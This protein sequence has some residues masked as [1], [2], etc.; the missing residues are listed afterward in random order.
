MKIGRRRNRL[1]EFAGAYLAASA[2][3]WLAPATRVSNHH[4][5]HAASDRRRHKVQHRLHSLPPGVTDP[6]ENLPSGWEVW[7]EGGEYTYYNVV[8][9]PYYER[10]TT[11]HPFYGDVRSAE[12]IAADAALE[13]LVAGVEAPFLPL[14]GP[15]E[16]EGVTPSLGGRVAGALPESTSGDGAP[17][18]A[19]ESTG[20]SGAW[21]ASGDAPPTG[22]WDAP[23]SDTYTP[24]LGDRVDAALDALAAD[25]EPYTPQLGGRVDAT[26]DALASE[27]AWDDSGAAEAS[28]DTEWAEPEAPSRALDLFA[29]ALTDEQLADAGLDESRVIG[30]DGRPLDADDAADGMPT[31]A[32]DVEDFLDFIEEQEEEEIE[33]Y[34]ERLGVVPSHELIEVDEDGDPITETARMTYVDEAT[35]IGCTLCAGIAPSTFQMTDDHGRARVFNQ[36]GEDEETITEAISTCPVSCIHFVPWDELVRLEQERAEVMTAYNFKSRLVGND[37]FLYAEGGG[38]SQDISTNS[39]LR[40]NN[41]PSNECEDCPMFGVGDRVNGKA[42]GNCPTNGCLGCPLATEYPEFSKIR[43]RRDRKRRNLIRQRKEEAAER[44]GLGSAE[45]RE[46]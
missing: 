13:A 38:Q 16:G 25:P 8:E 20:T 11:V 39:M 18:D 5:W 15:D 3:G 2:H 6:Q 41:C 29:S 37:G 9:D 33:F 23:A 17:R 28:W 21:D 14:D 26:L 44:L 1:F 7:D 31:A 12:A 27:T 43:A 42:C 22:A 45:G 36:E 46:L 4:V 10:P 35:C 19:P 32:V 24:P 34:D 40:C 30:L